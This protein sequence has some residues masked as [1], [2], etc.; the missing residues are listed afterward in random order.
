MP[1]KYGGEEEK[2][3]SRKNGKKAVFHHGDLN[4]LK[5]ALMAPA[6]LGFGGG[7][8]LG[9]AARKWKMGALVAGDLP[10]RKGKKKFKYDPSKEGQN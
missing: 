8:A 2:E 9:R 4:L 7:A 6:G 1:R 10:F 5:E 3:P